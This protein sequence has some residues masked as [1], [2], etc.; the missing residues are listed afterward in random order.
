MSADLSVA[1]RRLVAYETVPSAGFELVVTPH[2]RDWMDATYERSAYRCLPLLLANQAGWLILNP[3]TVEV[4]WDGGPN[5]DAIQIR[6]WQPANNA[7]LE[8]LPDYVWP[9]SHFGSGIV[10]W[11]LPYLFRTPPGYNLLA[12]GPANQ[13]KDGVAPLEGLV[14]TDW[15]VAT[16]TMNWKLTRSDTWIT[17]AKGEPVCM[18]VPQRRGELE[19][20]APEILSINDDPHL[21]GANERWRASRDK[22]LN[23]EELG[24]E[25][26]Y[27]KGTA[28]DGT[29]ATQHQTKLRLHPFKRI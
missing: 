28:P 14:E 24:W 26:H 17:F 21:S 3:V 16:F 8:K 19:E 11:A 18:V 15:A 7:T 13:I 5:R 10:T 25:K 27:F 2:N 4:K 9:T 23:A 29:T 12:R 22:L 20:F 1:D 6:Y